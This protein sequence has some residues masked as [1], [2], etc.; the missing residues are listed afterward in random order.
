MISEAAQAGQLMRL[1]RIY[2]DE[3]IYICITD[4]KDRGETIDFKYVGPYVNGPSR[5]Q[6]GTM[7]TPAP[8][9]NGS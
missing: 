9:L 1:E 8:P 5:P 2:Y 4:R 6:V 3:S 7:D